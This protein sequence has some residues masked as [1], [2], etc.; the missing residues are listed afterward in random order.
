MPRNSCRA[1]ERKARIAIMN[2]AEAEDCTDAARL[3]ALTRLAE[4][5]NGCVLE[6]QSRQPPPPKTDPKPFEEIY[7]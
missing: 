1:A 7:I 5:I 3:K 6:I 4:L 2:L